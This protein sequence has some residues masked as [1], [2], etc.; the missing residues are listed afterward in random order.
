MPVGTSARPPPARQLGVLAGDQVGAGIAGAG[1]RR[2]RQVGVEPDDGHL[3]HVGRSRRLRRRAR[4]DGSRDDR[5]RP[6]RRRH[7]RDRHPGHR[8]RA[9]R[10]RRGPR[11]RDPPAARRRSPRMDDVVRDMHTRS[12]L[13]PAIEASTVT[14]EEAARGHP[15][16]PQGRT[17]PSRAPS[18]CAA[19]RSAPT[20]AS[21]R[22][23][24]PEIEDHLHYRS[25]DVSTIKELAGAG[26]P[27]RP[28][29]RPARPAATG[30]STTSGRASTS[31]ATTGKPCSAAPE[32]R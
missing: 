12:G 17:S 24:L 10:R 20:A 3:Q 13:L 1:V 4:L 7:R 11:P 8:R 31:C 9:R 18:R 29:P 5:A 15:R 26:I 32:V 2:Q 14:L 21:S 30:P 19:T 27:R 28:R 23:Y 22:A 25:V 16:V 6:G